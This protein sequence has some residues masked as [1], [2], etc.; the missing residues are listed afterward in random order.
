MVDG[1]PNRPLYF[2]Q[3]DIIDLT[4]NSPIVIDPLSEHWKRTSRSTLQM[5]GLDR[6]RLGFLMGG[7]MEYW[8]LKKSLENPSGL[9][10][11]SNANKDVNRIFNRSV[12]FNRN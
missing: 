8:T 2:Y 7:S 9:R 10:N 11:I 1:I 12:N 6:R 4:Y 3:K 5:C